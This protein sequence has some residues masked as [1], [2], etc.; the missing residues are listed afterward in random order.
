MQKSDISDD[1]F[2]EASTEWVE[3]LERQAEK[4]I[5]RQ[6]QAISL[7][8][9]K[10]QKLINWLGVGSSGIVS[11]LLMNFDTILLPWTLVFMALAW[12][13]LAGWLAFGNMASS[14]SLTAY[15]NIA[16]MY[17]PA[18]DFLLARKTR[19]VALSDVQAHLLERNIQ[20]ASRFNL[21]LKL[22]II[23]PFLAAGFG[24]SEWVMIVG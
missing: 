6:E 21:A 9:E 17:H 15:G 1:Y 2:D 3:H 19:L 12:G 7:V 16:T 24:V 10:S 22:A 20:F 13:F 11:V 14:K 8:R 18:Y 4:G 5:F 23:I